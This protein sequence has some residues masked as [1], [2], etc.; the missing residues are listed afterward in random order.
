[1]QK[2]SQHLH[3]NC[4]AIVSSSA[5]TLLHFIRIHFYVLFVVAVKSENAAAA[6]AAA[7]ATAAAITALRPKI[8]ANFYYARSQMVKAKRQC[9]MTS[10]KTLAKTKNRKSWSV[11]CRVGGGGGRAR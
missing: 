1:M 2:R 3:C 8:C 5:P 10:P 11:L 9:H 6:A 7:T 4:N